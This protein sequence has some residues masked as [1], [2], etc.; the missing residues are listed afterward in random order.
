MFFIPGPLIA[1]LTFPGVMLHEWAHKFFCERMGVA[2]HKVKYFQFKNPSGYVMHEQPK[3]YPQTFWISVGPLLVNS[4]A[5]VALSFIAARMRT[6]DTAA[7]Y[8]VLFLFWIAISAGMHAFPS[9]HDMQHISGASKQAI[10]SGGGYLHYLAFPFVWLVWLAN[11][12]RFFWFDLI[13]A[14]LLISIGGGFNFDQ[15]PTSPATTSGRANDSVIVGKYRGPSYAA[16][17]AESLQAPASIGNKID[18]ESSSLDSRQSNLKDLSYR[19]DN[20]IVDR[21]DQQDIDRHNQMIDDY[22]AE[23]IQLK[24]DLSTFNAEVVQYNSQVDSYNGYL[25]RNCTAI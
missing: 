5:T 9:D 19:I 21:T 15:P 16:S 4:F 24:S 17:Q 8:I 18:Q 23:L 13:Y 12:L 2:V 20:D 11:K 1:A 3:T 7:A 10:K 22:N 25:R 14:G 6:D